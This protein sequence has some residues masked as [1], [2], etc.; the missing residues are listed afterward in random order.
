MH[1]TFSKIAIIAGLSI[2]LAACDDRSQQAFQSEAGAS[3]DEGGFGNPTL[4]NHLINT[5]QLSPTKQLAQRFDSEVA[6]TVTFDFNSATLSPQAQNTLR[7]Q[8]NWIKQFPE[9]RFRVYGHTDLV[10]SDG[11]NKALGLRRANAVVSFFARQGINRSRLEALASFGETRPVI[12]TAA[13]ERRNRRTVTEVSGFV[14][15]GGRGDGRL[16]DGKYAT[17]IYRD[18]VASGERTGRTEVAT[19]AVE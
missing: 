16:L 4:T 8:A 11:Y 13:R 15:A 1:A 10:G 14:G 18:Y 7:E 5:G 12:N 3:V 2:T 9:V 6:S 17:L 19:D